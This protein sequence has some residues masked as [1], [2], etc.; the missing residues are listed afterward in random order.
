MEEEASVADAAVAAN[1]DAAVPPK[2][3][4]SGTTLGGG[5]MRGE[6]GRALPE[7]GKWREQE[8]SCMPERSEPPDPGP[9][10]GV[11]DSAN[12][13]KGDIPAGPPRCTKWR[14]CPTGRIVEEGAVASLEAATAVVAA[15]E[16]PAHTIKAVARTDQSTVGLSDCAWKRQVERQSVSWRLRGVCAPWQVGE[17]PEGPAAPVG[18]QTRFGGRSDASYADS[19]PILRRPRL[20]E[21]R[22]FDVD[23]GI[24]APPVLAIGEASGL[25][26]LRPAVPLGFLP[27]LAAGAPAICGSASSIPPRLVRRPVRV[28]P[29]G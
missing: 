13:A 23:V 15:G 4:L 22:P 6:N 21:C 19:C 8:E 3:R 5:S 16:A 7:A 12:A 2:A 18:V 28:H 20:N 9:G 25:G 29:T 1:R 24:L 10:N 27:S 14:A 11:S 26:A 17:A